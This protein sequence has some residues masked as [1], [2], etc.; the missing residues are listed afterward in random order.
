MRKTKPHTIKVDTRIPVNDYKNLEKI[1][2]ENGFRSTYVLMRYVLMSFLRACDPQYDCIASP[3]PQDLCEVFNFEADRQ[4][5][6]SAISV[7]NRWARRH[8]R[9]AIP[10]DGMSSE[11]DAMF[12]ELM[13]ESRMIQFKADI[14]RRTER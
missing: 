13:E 11:I 12:C 9:N 10:P 5:V 4:V 7:I 1:A 3:L 14:L 6:K 8:H 2:Q